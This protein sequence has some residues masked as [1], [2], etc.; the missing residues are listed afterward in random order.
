VFKRGFR[1]SFFFLPPLL[2]SLSLSL[3]E[4]ERFIFPFGKGGLRG[5]LKRDCFVALAMT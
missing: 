3:Y 1:P 5:I 4:R 2:K